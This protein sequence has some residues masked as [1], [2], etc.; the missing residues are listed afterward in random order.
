MQNYMAALSQP[1][2]KKNSHSYTG[3]DLNSMSIIRYKQDAFP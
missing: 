2:R 1:H 3:M